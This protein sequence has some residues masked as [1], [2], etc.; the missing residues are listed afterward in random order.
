MHIALTDNYF[1]VVRLWEG[2]G[3]GLTKHRM[4]TCPFGAP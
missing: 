1:S 3:E 2:V 4:H